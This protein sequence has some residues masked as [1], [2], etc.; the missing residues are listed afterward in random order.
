MNENLYSPP[1]TPQGN[2]D[3]GGEAVSARALE[4]I[5]DH[6]GRTRSWLIFFVV[7]F[8]L[9]VGLASLGGL[10]MM[11]TNAFGGLGESIAIS[12]IYLVSAGVYGFYAWIIYK[13]VSAAGLVKDQP[14]AE[15]LIAFC[16]QNRRM[17][18]TFGISVIVIFILYFVVIVGFIV[19]AASAF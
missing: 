19:F 10:V 2:P 4:A 14:N 15:N 12:A 8:M 3:G 11:V 13:C 16:D 6:I 1:V 7:L 5:A 9:G 18:R 17:W